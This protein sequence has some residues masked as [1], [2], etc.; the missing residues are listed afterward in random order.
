[1]AGWT[2]IGSV[3]VLWW[4]LRRWRHQ[5][6]G[7]TPQFRVVHGATESPVASVGALSGG[8]TEGTTVAPVRRHGRGHCDQQ[9]RIFGRRVSGSSSGAGARANRSRAGN[10]GIPRHLVSLWGVAKTLV[11]GLVLSHVWSTWRAT[12]R[13]ETLNT[14][15][16]VVV[17]G[18]CREE[19]WDSEQSR[20]R[21]CGARDG[22]LAAAR[23]GEV[24]HLEVWRAWNGRTAQRQ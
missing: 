12:D 5:C 18:T 17:R 4:R 10:R 13:G 21:G 15:V 16:V 2:E 20:F 8:R 9:G 14:V 23:I 19:F 1:M 7:T 6:M 3:S 22:Y 24:R 11:I